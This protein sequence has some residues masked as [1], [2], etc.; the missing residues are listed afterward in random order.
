MARSKLTPAVH[1]AIVKMVGS[2]A[3]VETACEA[4]GIHKAQ[5]YRWLKLADDPTADKRYATFRD[6]TTRARAQSESQMIDVVMRSA[7]GDWRAAAWYLEHS[8]AERYGKREKVELTGAGG[9]PITL[10]G[11]AL[12]MGV[13]GD[14]DAEA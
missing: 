11:L 8:H 4:A 2:G 9:G 1:E 14:A 13:D 7:P 6:A 3:F 10:A 12:L 5:Y